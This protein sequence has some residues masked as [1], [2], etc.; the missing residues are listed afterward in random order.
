MR[1]RIYEW[2]LADGNNEE[3]F[4][5]CKH[6]LSTPLRIQRDTLRGLMRTCKRVS[7][8]VLETHY[9]TS[10]ISTFVSIRDLNQMRE[11]DRAFHNLRLRLNGDPQYIKQLD[12]T[13]DCTERPNWL[14]SQP[15]NFEFKRFCK[16]CVFQVFQNR[17]GEEF[18]HELHRE[19]EAWVC[20]NSLGQQV[21]ALLPLGDD[22]ECVP[23]RPPASLT[24]TETIVR[25]PLL[26]N[27]TLRF[28]G[29]EHD[30]KS[31]TLNHVVTQF[32]QAFKSKKDFA[33]KSECWVGRSQRNNMDW[34]KFAMGKPGFGPKPGRGRPQQWT[35]RVPLEMDEIPQEMLRSGAPWRDIDNEIRSRLENATG[36]LSKDHNGLLNTFFMTENR[37]S[38]CLEVW[39]HRRLGEIRPGEVMKS[40][41]KA[42]MNLNP[43]A[44]KD[45]Y[46]YPTWQPPDLAESKDS[47]AKDS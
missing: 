34:M 11:G 18:N 35:F 9:R 25:L 14:V 4:A 5:H 33:L 20:R 16:F 40:H 7:Q 6:R 24:N 15:K 47:P 2:A 44:C 31:S 30:L 10:R 32:L 45:D 43:L 28:V 41:E 36:L 27:V 3:N 38:I 29:I 37:H 12:V 42:I 13:V 21:R 46:Q 23:R 19:L 22:D 8:E 17:K 26:E 39:G 1:E